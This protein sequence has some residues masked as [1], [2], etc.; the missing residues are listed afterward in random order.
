MRLKTSDE[1]L[2]KEE[3]GVTRDGSLDGSREIVAKQPAKKTVN[4]PRDGSLD[5]ARKASPKRVEPQSGSGTKSGSLDD[6]RGV[7]EAPREIPLG[8]TRGGPQTTRD[9]SLDG[10]RSLGAKKRQRKG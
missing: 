3:Q 6:A 9:G 7:P 5:R 2:S 1:T 4:N 10:T 8:S